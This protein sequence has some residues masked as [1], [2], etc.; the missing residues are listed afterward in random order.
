MNILTE[1][2]SHLNVA[3]VIG[4]FVV[5]Y[6]VGMTGVGGGSLMTPFLL[7]FGVAPV[8]AVGTDLLYAAITKANGVFFHN[9]K[10]NVDW[11]ITLRLACGSL[12]ASI[13]TLALLKFYMDEA[14]LDKANAIICLSLG[15]ALLLTAAAILFKQALLDWSHRNDVFLTR[16]SESRRRSAT[17]V[18]GIFLG[19]VVTLTSIGAGA[20]GT[21]A[22]FLLFPLLPTSKLVGSEIAHAVPLTLIAGLGHASAGNVDFILLAN[23]LAGSLPGIWL[24]SHT[25]GKVSDK[26]LR[27]ALAAIL[28]VAGIKLLAA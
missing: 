14:Q 19:A 5:G 23:L 1:I 16:M 11:A 17:V 13:A 12:P 2:W 10:G 15:I 6:I 25:T 8:N 7:Q 20:L 3:Y 24:G 18:V 27:P 26:V 4:G 28:I 9:R 22:L 21:M